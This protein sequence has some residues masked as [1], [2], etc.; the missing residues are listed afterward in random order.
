MSI[1]SQA[2]VEFQVNLTSDGDTV[3]LTNEDSVEYELTGRVTRTDIEVDPGTKER[4]HEPKT[5]VTLSISDLPE[6]FA[7]EMSVSTTDVQGDDISGVVR[8]PEYDRTLGFLSF[9]IEVT[10]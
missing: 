1:R 7:E 8:S 4:F 2:A 10:G 5:R 6:D 9:I 3:T